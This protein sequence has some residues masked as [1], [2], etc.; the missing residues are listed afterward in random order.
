LQHFVLCSFAEVAVVTIW[1]R[2]VGWCLVILINLFFVFFAVLR[3]SQRSRSW[4]NQYIVSCVAQFFMEVFIFESASVIWVHWVIPRLVAHNVSIVIASLKVLVDSALSTSQVDWQQPIDSTDYFFVSKA[5]AQKYPHLL[6]SAVVLSFHSYFPPG[7]MSNQWGN[8]MILNGKHSRG[9][10]WFLKILS[11]ALFV[12]GLLQFVGTMN[13]NVQTF[14][15]SLVLPLAFVAAYV[16]VSFLIQHSIWLAV[17]AVVLL[18]IVAKHFI[19]NARHMRAIREDSDKKELIIMPWSAAGGDGLYT[20]PAPAEADGLVTAFDADVHD[21]ATGVVD[22]SLAAPLPAGTVG[23][24]RVPDISAL[25]LEVAATVTGGGFEQRLVVRD[26]DAVDTGDAVMIVRD[27]DIERRFYDC[28]F[29]GNRGNNEES[30]E[31]S[32]ESGDWAELAMRSVGQ[33]RRGAR[34]VIDA[35][36]DWDSFV[37]KMTGTSGSDGHDDNERV[38]SAEKREVDDEIDD[39]DSSRHGTDDGEVDIH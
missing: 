31:C 36:N 25:D 4:Q 29:S 21:A 34:G 15:M 37:S 16:A 27:I 38:R 14:I 5:I 30:D 32:D 19:T 22:T 24:A 12:V 23:L 11:L 10:S 18:C 3:A 20:F 33:G 9:F 7:R 8:N 13:M 39:G 17:V 2:R 28:Q 26:L 6:E 1:G 35:G